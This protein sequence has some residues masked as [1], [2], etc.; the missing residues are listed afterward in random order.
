M[1]IGSILRKLME[2]R[3]LTQKQLAIELNLLAPSLGRYIR[4]EREPDYET[5]KTIARYFNV[6]TDYLLC[7]N[8]EKADN[9]GEEELL[10]IY[11]SLSVEQQELYIEQG[12][13]FI[14]VNNKK[15]R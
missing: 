3:E 15:R 8:L 6:S 9:H 2:E 13:A 1:K 4:N 14:K 5:L 7:F 12:K 10:H 11:H